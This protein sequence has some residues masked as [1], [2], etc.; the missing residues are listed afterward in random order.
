MHN[1]FKLLL[2][3]LVTLTGCGGRTAVPADSYP[4]SRNIILFIGDGMGEA[5]RQA[6]NLSSTGASNELNMDTL[7]AK[8]FLHTAAA[9]NPVTD[10]A[11]AATAMAC[12]VKTNVGVLGMNAALEPVA[13]ILEKAK[14]QGKM[15]GLV[16]TGQIVDATPAAFAAHIRDRKLFV[17]I[18]D[19]MV[20]ADI[21]VLLGGGECAFLPESTS[22]Y[23]CQSGTRA[24]NRNLISEAKKRGVVHVCDQDSF[25]AINP[26]S[27]RHILGI[28]A[29]H[30]MVRPFTPSLPA[31]TRKAIDILAKGPMGFFLMIEAG[32]IDWASHANDAINA[33]ADTI[34]LDQAVKIAR[35]YAS[36]NGH[37]LLIVTAD[38]ET[39]GMALSRA[40]RH[41]PAEQGPFPMTEGGTFF[42][43]WTTTNH[44]SAD[45]PVTALGPGSARL[46]G[47][48]DNTFLFTVMDDAI[49]P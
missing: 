24:D 49:K 38:H 41:L 16:T 22:G 43:N 27:G 47:V 39:G 26:A 20:D 12:G 35:E 6:A 36:R 15:V 37:T 21:D 33:I 31:M 28:F 14:A 8:G 5:H 34:E 13:T 44:T 4:K 45:V 3:L 7:P 9:D 30:G 18:A 48:H 42:I 17:E 11:A 25:A 2:F 40:S 29:D 23:Y 10:S 1:F 46:N 32:Q 19:Q